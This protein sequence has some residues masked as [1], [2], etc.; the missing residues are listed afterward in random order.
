MWLSSHGPI[1]SGGFRH[2]DCK[3][4]GVDALGVRRSARESPSCTQSRTVHVRSACSVPVYVIRVSRCR[5]ACAGFG[6]SITVAESTFVLY[7]RGCFP[8]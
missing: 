3:A 4:D 5:T 8:W 6:Y 2:G 1:T 7:D